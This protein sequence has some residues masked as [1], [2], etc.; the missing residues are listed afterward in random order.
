MLWMDKSTL[1]GSVSSIQMSRV[2]GGNAFSQSTQTVERF[3]WSPRI[4]PANSNAI[5]DVVRA[6]FT[7]NVYNRLDCTW[8]Q[9]QQDERVFDPTPLK[10]IAGDV[11]L[12]ICDADLTQE[13]VNVLRESKNITFLGLYRTSS[14]DLDWISEL[15]NLQETE[16]VAVEVE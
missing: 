10:K 14:Q 6:G 3:A 16:F 9:D 13:Q 11:A 15:P 12:S 1:S 8:W 2:S 5:R 7:V 4:S